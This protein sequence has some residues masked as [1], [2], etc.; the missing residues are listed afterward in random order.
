MVTVYGNCKLALYD[1]GTFDILSV[2][3]YY[4]LGCGNTPNTETW[5]V[6]KAEPL[7][8]RARGP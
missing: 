6:P 1:G 5:K 2:E 3:N 7:N 4:S 8:S